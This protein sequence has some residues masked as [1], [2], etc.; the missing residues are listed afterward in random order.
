[1]GILDYLFKVENPSVE[2]IHQ[3]FDTAESR[4]IEEC[5]KILQSLNI[6]KN[7][8]LKERLLC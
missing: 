1:M 8:T 7:L 4:I 6:P 3:E 5:D 2:E